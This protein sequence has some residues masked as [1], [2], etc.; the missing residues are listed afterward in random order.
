MAISRL[1]EK[2]VTRRL[3]YRGFTYLNGEDVVIGVNFFLPFGVGAEFPDRSVPAGN[4]EPGGCPAIGR[5][6]NALRPSPREGNEEDGLPRPEA[7]QPRGATAIGQY[8]GKG[9]GRL[10]FPDA[11]ALPDGQIRN[12]IVGYPAHVTGGGSVPP[13]V[14]RSWCRAYRFLSTAQY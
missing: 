2:L 5:D 7:V 6:T 12:F 11:E 10:G 8:A 4:G 9:K 3:V 14:F 13:F 1:S